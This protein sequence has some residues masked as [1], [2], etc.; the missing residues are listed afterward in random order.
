M[1]S[2]SRLSAAERHRFWHPRGTLCA[3]CGQLP[4]G[5]GWRDPVRSKRPRSSVWFCSMACQSDWTRRARA[6]EPEVSSDVVRPAEPRGVVDRRL[7]RQRR[8]RP[9][10]GD[11][12][13]APAKLIVFG[14]PQQGAMEIGERLLH[15]GTSRQEGLDTQLEKGFPRDQIPCPG[16]EVPCSN[17]AD[18][19]AEG[20]Q[21]PADLVLVVAELVDVELA[22]RQQR[23]QLLAPPRLHMDGLEP[24]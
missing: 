7:E 15:H 10:A 23:A 5:F 12:H 14:Q 11:R 3:V 22:R 4:H 21:Q 6:G 19:Q 13:E 16:L 2:N 18:L 24:A 9:D 8:D 1:A 20:A 17:L